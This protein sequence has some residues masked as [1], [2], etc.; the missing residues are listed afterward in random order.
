MSALKRL[1]TAIRRILFRKSIARARNR[2][3]RWRRRHFAWSG[4]TDRR[5][6]GYFGKKHSRPKPRYYC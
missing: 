3:R 6:F 5:T 2:E 1:L 4:D